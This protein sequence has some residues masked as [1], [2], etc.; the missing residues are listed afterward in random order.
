M[1]GRVMESHGMGTL[2]NQP[3]WITGGGFTMG[4]VVLANPDT[5]QEVMVDDCAVLWLINAWKI[6]ENLNWFDA[7]QDMIC[8][9]IESMY[10]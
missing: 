8:N 6:Q 7:N 5:D 1:L 2:G 3:R 9:L 4:I 10:V